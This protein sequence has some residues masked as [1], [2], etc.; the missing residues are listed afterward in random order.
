MHICIYILN[1]HI[2]ICMQAI[3]F[4][5]LRQTEDTVVLAGLLEKSTL[6]MLPKCQ[7]AKAASIRLLTRKRY[8][9]LKI[10]TILL[11]KCGRQYSSIATHRQY[12]ASL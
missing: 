3:V 8:H 5:S 6:V 11:E 4:N 7:L 1:M 2:Y 12:T 9:W 10:T